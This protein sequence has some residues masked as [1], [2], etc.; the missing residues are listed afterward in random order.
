MQYYSLP[1]PIIDSIYC[2]LKLISSLPKRVILCQFM[3]KG[4]KWIILY[5]DITI[6]C[7]KVFTIRIAIVLVPRLYLFIS[8]S[9]YERN[10][11]LN[12]FQKRFLLPLLMPN[13]LITK[14]PCS[15]ETQK[16]FINSSHTLDDK[17]CTSFSKFDFLQSTM[18][19]KLFVWAFIW[20]LENL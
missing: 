16:G 9:Y 4:V 19:G 17:E 3:V 1:A 5:V 8:F 13:S 11:D 10:D 7:T 2:P 12:N 20:T 18:H 14:E 6:E 15:P